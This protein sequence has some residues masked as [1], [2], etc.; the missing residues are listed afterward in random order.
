MHTFTSCNYDRY[1]HYIPNHLLSFLLSVCDFFEDKKDALRRC[2]REVCWWNEF[3]FLGCAWWQATKHSIYINIDDEVDTLTNG[4][5]GLIQC[6]NNIIKHPPSC[7]LISLVQALTYLCG[8]RLT[9]WN[10]GSCRNLC[11]WHGG[12]QKSKKSKDATFSNLV[13]YSLLCVSLLV[14]WN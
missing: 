3:H 12:T 7:Y 2:L 8:Y 11:S 1:S 5:G 10:P 4:E 13:L 6:F 14:F 9:P